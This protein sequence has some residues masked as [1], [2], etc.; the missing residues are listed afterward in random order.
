VNLR[1]LFPLAAVALSLAAGGVA[2]GFLTDRWGASPDL[3]GR[4]AALNGMNPLLGDWAGADEPVDPAQLPQVAIFNRRYTQAGTGRSCLVTVAVGR[5]GR[6]AIHTPEY[7]YPGAGYE[8]NSAIDRQEI[9]ANNGSPAQ[10]W[11][12]VFTRKKAVGQDSIRIHWAWASAGEW[13]A[14]DFPRVTFARAP[15]LQKVYLVHPESGADAPDDAP[16]YE[17][18][19]AQV[20]TELN[21]KLFARP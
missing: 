4:L 19:A 14:P 21:R 9:P 16:A 15:V 8:L 3:D 10:L 5:P 2:Q 6:V 18:F 17:A 1:T 7:C 13:R 11:T 12:A 20:L